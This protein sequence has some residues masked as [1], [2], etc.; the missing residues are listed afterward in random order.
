MYTPK[1]YKLVPRMPWEG[2]W[3][4]GAP[5][6]PRGL[7]N[8]ENLEVAVKPGLPIYWCLAITTRYRSCEMSAL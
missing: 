2:S 8:T 4:L 7:R 6:V 3:A 1:P 5:R